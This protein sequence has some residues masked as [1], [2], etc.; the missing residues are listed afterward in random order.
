MATNGAK[1]TRGIYRILDNTYKSY[2]LY[3]LTGAT[4][5]NPLLTEQIR[6][7]KNRQY[8]NG[9]GFPDWLVIQDQTKWSK[10][11]RVTGLRPTRI[12]N[13]FEGNQPVHKNNKLKPESLILVQF[14]EDR[15]TA[16]IDIFYKYYPYGQQLLNAMLTKHEFHIPP[17]KKE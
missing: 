5:E 7:E 3:Q 10:C 16:V 6:I 12:Q 1:Y 11:T 8:N 2:E 9:K 14:S 17:Q 15:T 13:V 4:D